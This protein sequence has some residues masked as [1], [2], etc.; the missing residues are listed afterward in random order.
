MNL[1]N[2]Y[3]VS[4]RFL[5]QATMFPDYMLARV[6]AQYRGKYR[7]V[8]EQKELMAEISGK[9][10]YDTNELAMYPAVGDYVMIDVVG[11]TAVIHHVLTRKSLF[12]RKAVGVL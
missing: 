6:V 1:L 4:E 8:T 11:N 2:Q 7:I 10:R 5:A 3:G 12:A 9:L